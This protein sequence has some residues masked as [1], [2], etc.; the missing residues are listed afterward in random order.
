MFDKH[1][2]TVKFILTVALAI[3]VVQSVGGLVTVIQNRQSNEAQAALR[4][5]S[6]AQVEA[7]QIE[8]MRGALEQKEVALASMLSNIGSTY[9]VGYDFDSLQGLVDI[10]VQDRDI[11]FVEFHDTE[12]NPLTAPMER[13]GDDL[14]FTHEVDFD[15]L[16]VGT[17]T[18]GV[19]TASVQE[20]T[21]A[22]KEHLAQLEEK[23]EAQ[24]AAAAT[25]SVAWTV[26]LGLA[27]IL[28]LNGLVWLLMTRIIVGP[29]RDTVTLATDMANGDLS[30]DAAFAD[31]KDEIG[32]LGRAFNTLIHVWRDTLQ[33]LQLSSSTLK[34]TADSLTGRSSQLADDSENMTAISSTVSSASEELST[35]IQ[36][37]AGS[38]DDMSQMLGTVASSI[39]EMSA[40]IQEVA[41]NSER[42]SD[43]AEQANQLSRSTV[44]IMEQFKTT[45]AKIG[46]VIEVITDIAD[47]TNLLA[48]N[49]TIE[50][51]SAGESGKG[52]AVVAYE[53]KELARQTSQA[54][55]EINRE[56]EEM[57][58]STQTAVDAITRIDEVIGEVNDIST[59]I[60]ATVQQQSAALNEIAKSGGVANSAAK[61]ISRQVKEGASGTREISRSI[62]GVREAAVTTDAGVKGT[63]ED[64]GRL[65][66]LAEGM[67][68]LVSQFQI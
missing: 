66:E 19:S 22:M 56:I 51:A 45:S 58:R 21:A 9:I 33:K 1:S 11:S 8:Q 61:E 37:I 50:A 54:T 6:F 62:Q 5:E 34:N 57:Q 28:L 38:A 52:F 29:L 30:N 14:L 47:Q 55:E 3:L 63:R 67:D 12:G 7:G 60:A 40:S 26:G 25:R 32:E 17:M 15:G 4:N 43:I 16:P 35:S 20:A 10:A 48:L 24:Q 13:G 2:L 27:T 64:S 31:R 59:T 65:S 23:N 53:V 41:T 68:E 18:V 46:R 44:E 42:G 39:E 49:A 36:G